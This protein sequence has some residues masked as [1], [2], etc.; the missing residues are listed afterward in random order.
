MKSRRKP[1]VGR[2]DDTAP[3]CWC[4]NDVLETFSDDYVRCSQCETLVL[5]CMPAGDVTHVRNDKTD[6]Y[7]Q[8]YHR[9][10]LQEDFGY[11]DLATRVRTDLS[12]RCLHWFRAVLKYKVPPGK[13]LELGSA[14]GAFVALL[15]WSGFD[16]VG[17]E[18]S[19]WI[20]DFARHTFD[21][22]ML[23]GPIE[24]QTIKPQSLD[25]IAL[26]DVLEHFPSPVGTLEHCSHLLKEA[27]VLVIQTPR[28]PEGRTHK[29]MI[30]HKDRFLEQ[31]K[32]GEHLYLYSQK[33]VQQLL[34]RCGAVHVAFEPAIFAHYDMF[35]VAAKS[36]LPTTSR[37]QIEAALGAM[38][39]A[40][41]VQS[42]LDVDDQSRNLQ[43]H[44][45][46]AEADRAARLMVIHQQ[47]QQTTVLESEVHRWLEESKK[48]SVQAQQLEAARAELS[49]QVS[50]L[51]AEDVRLVE[52]N[53]QLAGNLTEA[54][55]RTVAEINGLQMQLERR[56][57]ENESFT[58]EKAKLL[59]QSA[60]I[61]SALTAIE[62]ERAR[63]VEDLE[64]RR[65]ENESLT[66]E[67]AELLARLDKIRGDLAAAEADRSRMSAEFARYSGDLAR[68][69]AELAA[70]R[71]SHES[72]ARELQATKDENRRLVARLD[73]QARAL[74]GAVKSLEAARARSREL[75]ARLSEIEGYPLVRVLK[76]CRL[77]TW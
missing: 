33:S 28:Y 9:K 5:R 74:D 51:T 24:D 58:Q 76:A 75:Q 34:R 39:A 1:A 17:L 69:Q 65:T 73:V 30:A 61:Q 7:G 25:V 56:R 4:G 26:M 23:L 50:R 40:R 72:L 2:H 37:E 16:A 36:P 46:I 62:R 44:L 27:G 55:Q 19:P 8:D 31:L 64:R 41:L 54:N 43:E 42:L 57:V 38:P 66:Q 48:L 77:W 32:P 3:V 22:P 11:P 10:H 67:K 20:V 49:E 45:S 18:L 52:E 68:L 59:A 53:K 70:L 14:H 13:A 21:V 60:R 15:R 47:G 29:E 6:L 71:N 63:L 12:E 35:L